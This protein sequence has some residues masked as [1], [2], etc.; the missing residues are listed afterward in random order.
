MRLRETMGIDMTLIAKR[1]FLAGMMSL[2][3]APA[4]VRADSI[5][6]VKKPP[7]ALPPDYELLAADFILPFDVVLRLGGGDGAAGRSLLDRWVAGVQ[8]VIEAERRA[9][10]DLREVLDNTNRLGGWTINGTHYKLSGF[11]IDGDVKVHT[12]LA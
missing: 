8:S 4:I 3:G 1:S 9:Q 10:S 6:P 12:T 11:E 7:L 2:L 5:M